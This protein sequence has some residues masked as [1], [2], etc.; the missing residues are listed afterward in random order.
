M[1]DPLYSVEALTKLDVEIDEMVC[2][3]LHHTPPNADE[4]A[5]IAV[6]RS[7]PRWLG[8]MAIPRYSWVAGHTSCLKSANLCRDFTE[9]H[10]AGVLTP[11]E[12]DI[13]I[14]SF[15]NPARRFS[16]HPDVAP[17]S[18]GD[19]T[20]ESRMLPVERRNLS[21]VE[22][23]QYIAAFWH[24]V[25]S[26]LRRIG[27]P[28]R[29][30]WL[31]S[32]AHDYAN[33]WLYLSRNSFSWFSGSFASLT[34]KEYSQALFNLLL[35]RSPHCAP[36]DTPCLCNIHYK[37]PPGR[38]PG[39]NPFHQLDCTAT[40]CFRSF[41][42][43]NIS[44]AFVQ[45][46]KKRIP[47]IAITSTPHL[48]LLNATNAQSIN[49]LMADLLVT[50]VSRSGKYID[51]T[52][53]NPAAPTY[54]DTAD[55]SISSTVL[56]NSTNRARELVKL[57]K[58]SDVVGN[59]VTNGMFVPFSV[60]STGRIGERTMRYLLELFPCDARGFTKAVPLIKQ[61]GIILAQ[62]NARAAIYSSKRR[63][64]ATEGDG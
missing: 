1:L 15:A 35:I 49:I 52:V 22:M 33:S 12:V 32:S 31:L 24:H 54:H 63:V 45:Y 62:Y 51:F 16:S 64:G 48:R 37:L 5:V 59:I 4:A 50:P 43:S 29:A 13:Q 2:R 60:E 39:N 21:E 30:A 6:L 56:V 38:F 27:C 11:G 42:H 40:K 61:I 44:R 46:V 55:P 41:C 3:S 14:G 19:E 7:L 9:E 34:D 18:Q 23:A 26:Y 20:A 17:S 10:F 47:E 53:G 57:R 58:Y 28:D 36:M 8:G 25:H